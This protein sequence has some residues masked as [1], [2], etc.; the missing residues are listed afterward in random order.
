MPGPGCPAM[1][2]D[3]FWAALGPTYL[4]LPR[5]TFPGFHSHQGRVLIPQPSPQAS[6]ESAQ[7][8]IKW[9]SGSQWTLLSRRCSDNHLEPGACGHVP[10]LGREEAA[11]PRSGESRVSAPSDLSTA[12]PGAPT[13]SPRLRT[14]GPSLT[15][16]HPVR[17]PARPAAPPTAGPARRRPR[18]RSIALRPSPPAPGAPGPGLGLRIPPPGPQHGALS[19]GPAG[20]QVPA[21]RLQPALLGETRSGEGRAGEGPG[22]GRARVPRADRCG[23]R[24]RLLKAGCSKMRR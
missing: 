7:S 9:V 6:N 15:L 18:P 20:Y 8:V 14:S 2:T 21:A 12:A 22:E 23:V 16:F 1:G 10:G 11:F 3:S 17:A 4:F 13:Q 24:S 19:R 5:A